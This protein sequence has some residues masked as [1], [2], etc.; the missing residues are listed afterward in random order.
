L[1]PALPVQVEQFL[2]LQACQVVLLEEQFQ[3]LGE[4]HLRQLQEAR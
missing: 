4:H 1:D 2:L 3:L